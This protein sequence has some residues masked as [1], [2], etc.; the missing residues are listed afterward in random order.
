MHQ[1]YHHPS[2]EVD[3]V[4]FQHMSALVDA[5]EEAVRFLGSGPT[6]AWKEGGR[7]GLEGG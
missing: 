3:M 2:D 6:P 7:E 5:A 1:D 4:D